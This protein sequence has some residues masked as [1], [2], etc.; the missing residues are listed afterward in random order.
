MGDHAQ[1][2]G[3]ACVSVQF[4]KGYQQSPTSQPC[5]GRPDALQASAPA[6]LSAEPNAFADLCY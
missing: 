3:A 2:K 4:N 6:P 5:V 1:D